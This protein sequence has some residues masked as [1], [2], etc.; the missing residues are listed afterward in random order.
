MTNLVVSPGLAVVAGAVAAAGLVMVVLGLMRRPVS[1]KAALAAL[2]ETRIT[3]PGSEA[4]TI[5]RSNDPTTAHPHDSGIAPSHDPGVALSHDPGIALSHDPVILREVAGSGRL[6]GWALHLTQ[7]WHLQLSDST[8]QLLAQ[9]RRTLGDFMTAK[10]L[11]ALAGLVAPALIT[12]LAWVLGLV[13]SPWPLGIGVIGAV[14]GFFWPDWALRQD[15]G[16]W[17]ES[18]ADAV[19]VYFDLVTL[20]RL[21]NASAVQALTEAAELAD[22]PVFVEIKDALNR[23]RLQQRPPWVELHQLAERL[24]LSD[25]GDLAD[26][27]ALDEQGAALVDALRARVRELRKAHL[28]H[29]KL[30]AQKQAESM[31]VWMVVPVLVFALLFLIPPL[32]TMMTNM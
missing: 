4:P 19:S 1:L 20:I 31:T 22:A 23:A 15:A 12:S 11:L 27:M 28:A 13:A 8:R 3:N 16:M 25:I 30:A 26:I 7:T 18:S 9:Q 10:L 6:E 29:A 17:R 14:L 21:G 5:A 32:M 2:D 24:D